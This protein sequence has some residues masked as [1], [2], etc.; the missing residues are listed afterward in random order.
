[1]ACA[2]Q[3]DAARFAAEAD[4]EARTAEHLRF[5]VNHVYV[6]ELYERLARV[7]QQRSARFYARSRSLLGIEEPA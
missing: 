4:Y 5:N 6:A 2:V 7:N 1:M 3:R